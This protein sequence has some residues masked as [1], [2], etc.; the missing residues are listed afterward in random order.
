MLLWSS[1]LTV[2]SDVSFNGFGNDRCCI[3]RRPMLRLM[4]SPFIAPDRPIGLGYT[5]LACHI[6]LHSL[7]YH[8]SSLVYASRSGFG[9][10]LIGSKI[11]NL[12]FEVQN[13]RWGALSFEKSSLSFERKNGVQNTLKCHWI[14][15]YISYYIDGGWAWETRLEILI[16][17]TGI[18]LK[19]RNLVF[20]ELA[21]QYWI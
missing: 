13:P 10:W 5:T 3:D 9:I 14:L 6:Y 12:W 15:T 16:L 2:A 18:A 19:R 4:Q 11:N 7:L 8:Q 17:K 20:V 21:Y 1:T